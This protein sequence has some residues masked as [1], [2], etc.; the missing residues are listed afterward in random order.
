ML[1]KIDSRPIEILKLPYCKKQIKIRPYKGSQEKKL[2]NC[3]TDAKDRKK[4][5][6]NILDI[7]QENIVDCDIDL[8]KIKIID[9][10]FIAFKLRSIS[11]S[12]RFEFKLPCS[13]TL[14]NEKGEEV[15]CTHIFVDSISMDSLLK[16]KNSD[17]LNKTVQINDEVTLVVEPPSVEYLN[18]MADLNNEEYEKIEDAEHKLN[19]NKSNKD[20]FTKGK[21]D[22]R[23]LFEILVT[24]ASFSVVKVIIDENGKKTTYTDF[25]KQELLDN[26]L[27]NLTIDDIKKLVKEINGLISLCIAITKKCP[28]CGKV[29]EDEDNS[30]FKFLT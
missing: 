7:I 25:T 26:I 27:M 5:L 1:P 14:K 18:Y 11:K 8:T 23:S 21:E 22:F 2:L 4:W 15:K 28:K 10:L 12:D 9:L 29:I 6:A 16:I 3:L 17:I 13:G 30:F 19:K 24:K 20:E